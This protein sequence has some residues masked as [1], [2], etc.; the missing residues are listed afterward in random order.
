MQTKSN[1]PDTR[2]RNRNRNSIE[3]AVL[4]IALIGLLAVLAVSVFLAI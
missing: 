4:S 1:L 2:K 3:I